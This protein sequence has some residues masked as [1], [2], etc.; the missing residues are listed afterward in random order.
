MGVIIIQY[1]VYTSEIHLRCISVKGGL[2][3][4]Q[5]WYAG[6]SDG[7]FVSSDAP[8]ELFRLLTVYSSVKETN[9]V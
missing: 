1:T 3:Y 6:V 5:V 9:K 2:L 4:T 7:A 8:T